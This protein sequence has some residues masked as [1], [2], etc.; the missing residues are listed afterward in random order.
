M[1]TL[2]KH[3]RQ[4]LALGFCLFSLLAYMGASTYFSGYNCYACGSVSDCENGNPN[5]QN[6]WE[7]CYIDHGNHPKCVVTGSYGECEGGPPV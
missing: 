4:I 5:L 1:H 6:A 2:K 7:G 3:V